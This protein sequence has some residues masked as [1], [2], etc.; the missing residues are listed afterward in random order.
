[1]LSQ[2]ANHKKQVA[3]IT[4]LCAFLYFVSYVTRNNYSAIISEIVTSTGLTKSALSMALTG[5]FITYGFSQIISGYLGDKIQ[6]RTLISAGMLITSSMNLLIPLCT[7][8][9]QM[10]VVW[11]INGFSQA[12][13]WPPIV[14]LMYSQMS[15]EEYDQGCVV[16][17]RGSFLGNITVYLLAPLLILLLSW[18]SVFYFSASMGILGLVLCWKLCPKISLAPVS[19]QPIPQA[20]EKAPNAI[21]LLVFVIL[22]II[23]NGILRDGV[24]TWMP[25]YISETYGLRNE[26]SILSGTALPIFSILCHAITYYLYRTKLRNP[27]TCTAVLYGTSTAIAQLMYIFYDQNALLSIVFCTLL[28]GGMHGVNLILIGILPPYFSRSGNVST[29]SGLLNACIYVGSALSAYIVP[30]TTEWAGW[31]A[32]LLL[33]VGFCLLGTILCVLCI[34]NWKMLKAI[35]NII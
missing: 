11:C 25:S 4:L 30:A 21:L 12:F 32:S 1:M 35:R 22:S 10:T 20:K 24:T 26:L 29:F 8:S 27:F 7:D 31:D 33:W 3:R 5:S 17:S 18:H 2:Q 14:K 9:I 16:V 13:M 6:P 34:R 28:T 23:M 19:N 15:V